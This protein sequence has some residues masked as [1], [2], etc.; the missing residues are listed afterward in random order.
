MKIRHL[1][2]LVFW[3]CFCGLIGGLIYGHQKLQVARTSY[4]ASRMHGESLAWE[5]RGAKTRQQEILNLTITA[6]ALCKEME[7]QLKEQ[8]AAEEVAR[9]AT[10]K[11]ANNNSYAQ[12]QAKLIANDPEYQKLYLAQRRTVYTAY[13]RRLYKKLGL[14]QE[15]IRAFEDLIS[16]RE[17]TSLDLMASAESQG[18]KFSDP[19]YAKTQEAATKES[20]DKLTTLIG[21]EGY[22]AFVQYRKDIGSPIACATTTSLASALFYTETPLKVEQADQLV[23][24][25][26]ANTTRQKAK[27]ETNWET[28]LT[29]AETILTPEQLAMLKRQRES[30]KVA[31]QLAEIQRKLT[32]KPAGS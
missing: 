6:E 11:R 3:L 9:A 17:E 5:L 4:V 2:L 13:Y 21:K 32:V 10:A 12:T 25:V 29:Q 15:A 23:K 14:T 22:D 27:A 28:V 26:D 1:V 31:A 8:E 20:A 7:Q 16:A 24:I 30:A 18:L 19:V